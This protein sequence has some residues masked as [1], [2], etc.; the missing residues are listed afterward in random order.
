[1]RLLVVRKDFINRRLHL[2]V[3]GSTTK[4]VLLASTTHVLVALL[5]YLH[6]VLVEL[7]NDPLLF[8]EVLLVATSHKDLAD[9]VKYF[10]GSLTMQQK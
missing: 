7:L 6:L 2:R 1:M 9:S 4:A 8:I 3:S 10:E 5:E